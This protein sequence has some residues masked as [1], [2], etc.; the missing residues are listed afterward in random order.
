[1]MRIP[2]MALLLAAPVAAQTGTLDQVSPFGGAS[3]NVDSTTLTWQQ[4]VRVG[5]GGTLEGL[6]FEM[7]APAATTVDMEIRLGDAWSNAA[8]AWTGAV[9]LAGLG[10]MESLYIDLTSAA[11]NL[12]ANDTFVFQL[13]GTGGGAWMSGNYIAPPGLPL[14]PEPLWLNQSAY[15]NGGWC[16]G[17]ESYM[18]TG[19]P[20]PSLVIVGSCPSVA[21]VSMHNM[22][23]SGRIVIA[24]APQAGPA[25]VSN[26]SQCLGAQIGLLGPTLRIIGFADANGDF[27]LNVNLPPAV[28]GAL[29]VQGFDVTTCVGTNVLPL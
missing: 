14:Y 4:Q 29:F 19:P 6:R 28:C 23:P 7:S 25:T 24:S 26:S 20:P 13:T 12:A 11:I 9:N 27:L 10:V 1:M 16:L 15:S 5:V 18:L 21:Q 22:T 17:F 2:L 3:F 8:P